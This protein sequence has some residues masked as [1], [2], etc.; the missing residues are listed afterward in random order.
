[1][2][3]LS[4]MECDR[5]SSWF[6]I[7]DTSHDSGIGFD[8]VPHSPS[9]PSMKL[10]PARRLD[11][12]G[13]LSPTDTVIF[14]DWNYCYSFITVLRVLVCAYPAGGRF[15]HCILV[16]LGPSFLPSRPSL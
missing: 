3:A 12:A 9:S 1:V 14:I 16:F 5:S 8:S 11:F 13:I 15:A 7:D 4:P 6:D 2:Q 10:T